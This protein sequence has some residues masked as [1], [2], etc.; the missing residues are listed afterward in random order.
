MGKGHLDHI[1]VGLAG[2]DNAGMFPNRHAAPFPFFDYLGH[3]LFYQCANFRKLCTTPVTQLFDPL[4]DQSRWIT[5]VVHMVLFL[6]DMIVTC[7]LGNRVMISI[8]S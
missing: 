2:A 8:L 3:R 4:V 6:S 5:L 7:T 1:F